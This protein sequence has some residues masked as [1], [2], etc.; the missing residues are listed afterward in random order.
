MKS[1]LIITAL[2]VVL[3]VGYSCKTRSSKP[4]ELIVNDQSKA[5]ISN[6]YWK[7]IEIGGE[8]LTEKFN[9]DPF[10]Q[11]DSSAKR[12]TGNG[13]CN[14]F[15]GPFELNRENK[16]SIG[17]LYSTKMACDKMQLEQQLLKIL[18]STDSFAVLADTLILRRAGSTSLAKFI[19]TIKQ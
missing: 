1:G 6:K 14:S 8:V 5:E 3:M 13:G 12:I 2:F 9:K 11:F 18:E 4:G 19:A 17:P 15:G 7:L 16:L 10:I